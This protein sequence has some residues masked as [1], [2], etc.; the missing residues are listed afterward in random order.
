MNKHVDRKAVVV[1][2]IVTT[3]ALVGI[4]A[5]TLVANPP[6]ADADVAVSNAQPLVIDPS[7][8][9]TPAQAEAEIAA[10]QVRLSEAYQAL[11]QAYAQ[12]ELL[13]A[14]QASPAEPRS[15]EEHEE[16]G[17]RHGHVIFEHEHEHEDDHD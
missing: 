6:A 16:G 9:L 14:G 5:A 4:G 3:I 13:Q 11:E 17:S 15:W 12:I 10:Y 2:A 8:T 1:S 7:Q